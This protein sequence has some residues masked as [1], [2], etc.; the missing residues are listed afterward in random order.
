MI[1]LIACMDR[2]HVIGKDNQIPWHLPADLKYFKE[3]TMG[4]TVVMGRKTFESIGKPLPGRRNVILTRDK[5]FRV[6]GAEVVHTVEEVLKRQEDLFII[7]GATIYEQFMP[8]AEKLY[9]TKIEAEFEGDAF[10]PPID[11]TWQLVTCLP[12]VQDEKNPYVFS[13]LTYEK[14]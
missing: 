5:G 10:F 6:E 13:F 8:Y 1:A 2:N 7:G 9:I 3:T 11:E 12:G 14:R 4:H